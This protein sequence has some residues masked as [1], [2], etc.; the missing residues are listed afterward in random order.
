MGLLKT[1][2]TIG[3]GIGGF[4]VGGPPG[5]LTGAS[6][7]SQLGGAVE[8]PSGGAGGAISGNLNQALNPGIGP[9]LRAAR[10]SAP[11]A[12]EF[13]EQSALRGL[14]RQSAGRLGALQATDARLQAGTRALDAFSGFQT[15]RL[16]A[17]VNL[18]GQD[19][20]RRGQVEGNRLSFL[21]NILGI[22]G[23]LIGSNLGAGRGPFDFGGSQ[24]VAVNNPA[25]IDTD[26]IT[27]S[28][29]NQTLARF[30]R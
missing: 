16:G 20:A 18:R 30:G 14:G 27:D 6:L 12:A 22:G 10:A 2:G 28:I 3:G 17:L 15:Q 13:Q 5:A 4:V 9:F 19:L 24:A 23:G 21:N 25:P 8:G 11:T 29:R 7:G 1:L 26:F